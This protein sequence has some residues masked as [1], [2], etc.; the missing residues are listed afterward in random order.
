MLWSLAS[1]IRHS[2]PQNASSSETLVRC[3]ATVTDLLLIRCESGSGHAVFATVAARR[4]FDFMF[5]PF[6]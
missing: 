3:P 6:H 5:G 4:A 2:L 1:A